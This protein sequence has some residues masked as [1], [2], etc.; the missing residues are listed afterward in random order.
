MLLI[1]QGRP[2]VTR[3]SQPLLGTLEEWDPD[4]HV[5]RFAINPGGVEK[6]AERDLLAGRVQ[7]A[8]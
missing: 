8:G 1:V 6:E 5:G 3:E 7:G 2:A 4:L